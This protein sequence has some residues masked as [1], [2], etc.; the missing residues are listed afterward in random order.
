MT[1]RSISRI[2]TL[3][4]LSSLI[5]LEVIAAA[6]VKASSLSTVQQAKEDRD[7]QLRQGLPGRRLGGGT[8]SGSLYSR[9]FTEDEV[10]LTALV[11]ADNLSLTSAERPSFTFYIPEMLQDQQAEFVLRNAEDE[12]V[13]E[14]TFEIEKS[15]GLTTIETSTAEIAPLNIGQNYT[16]YFSIVPNS[17]DRSNDII[18]YGNIRRV[19]STAAQS[20]EQSIVPGMEQGIVPSIEHSLP[21]ATNA[22]TLRTLNSENQTEA[23]LGYARRLREETALWHDAI[24]IV[25]KLYQEDPRNAAIAD[26]WNRLLEEV[27]L[28]PVISTAAEHTSSFTNVNAHSGL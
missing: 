28:S 23:L 26:E 11:T 17:V 2:A 9:V 6:Q 8:R 20:I 27:G 21:T 15:G 22:N 12:L 10:Y 4:L 1:I 19:E 5:G 14:T 25:G 18:V 24:S 7:D 13:Y 3:A 16:W